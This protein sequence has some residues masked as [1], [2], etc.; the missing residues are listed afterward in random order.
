MDPQGQF[1]IDRGIAAAR[2]GRRAEAREALFRALNYE[3]QR[4]TAWLWLAAVADDVRQERVYL[5]KVLA[6]NP[7]N[8]YARAGLAKLEKGQ[9]EMPQSPSAAEEAG[10]AGNGGDADAPAGQRDREM[11]VESVSSVREQPEAEQPEAASLSGTA[12]GDEIGRAD[13]GHGA[14]GASESSLSLDECSSE[15]TEVGSEPTG[16]TVRSPAIG[17]D[18]RNRAFEMSEPTGWTRSFPSGTVPARPYRRE[19]AYEQPMLGYSAPS[20]NGGQVTSVLG[21]VFN[22][23]ELW[24]IVA[25]AVGLIV[26]AIILIVVLGASLLSI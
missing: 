6:L 15:N 1:W 22:S 25:T 9:I 10:T 5:E 24:T 3:A 19:F 21:E 8:K 23:H 2:A 17:K 7:A 18:H 11:I 26:L 14:L 13:D 20:R 12:A 4:E 16:W